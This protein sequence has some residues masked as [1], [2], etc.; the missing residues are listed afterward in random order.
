MASRPTTRHVRF[1]RLP[2]Q[3]EQNIFVAEFWDFLEGNDA[4]S[5]EKWATE[6]ADIMNARFPETKKNVLRASYIIHARERIAGSRRVTPERKCNTRWYRK[7]TESEDG[8]I[9]RL[10]YRE[11]ERWHDAFLEEGKDLGH[12]N[13][14][15]YAWNMFVEHM[16][17]KFHITREEMNVWLQT[18]ES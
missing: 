6:A 1:D 12:E 10:C 4:K 16:E 14:P 11:Y 18:I 15:L 7:E 5:I 9:V 3:E 8:R 2:T 13:P 17:R